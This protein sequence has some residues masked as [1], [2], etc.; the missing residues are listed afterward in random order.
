MIY[1][2]V[3]ERYDPSR[4]EHIPSASRG[5][6]EC[7]CSCDTCCSGGCCSKGATSEEKMLAKNNAPTRKPPPAPP[8]NP[9]TRVCWQHWAERICKS[10]LFY[11]KVW[12][13]GSRKS[14]VKLRKNVSFA[15]TWSK[16]N[17]DSFPCVFSSSPLL[18]MG[19]D[20]NKSHGTED[21]SKSIIQWS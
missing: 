15:K 5:S 8:G 4:R 21:T 13:W 6:G 16:S 2:N 17:T 3:T 19:T 1:V 7:G 10:W 14:L 20:D 11:D 18:Q 9:S 12:K